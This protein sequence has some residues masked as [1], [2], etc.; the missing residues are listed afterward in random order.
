MPSTLMGLERRL[1]W[2]DFA[3]VTDRPAGVP[4]GALAETKTVRTVTG[5]SV[6]NLAKAGQPDA[7]AISDSFVMHLSLGPNSW[8]LG[9]NSQRSTS[10]EAWLLA[11]EQGHYDI[12][13]L[14]S[15]DY[16]EGLRAM[17]GKTF[18]SQS[19]L[20]G[21]MASLKV[22]ILDRIEEVQHAYDGDTKNSQNGE[23]QWNWLGLIRRARELHR[24]PLQLGPDGRYLKL[25]LLSVLKGRSL[26]P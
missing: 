23:E 1:K 8:R 9:S 19:A 6:A 4:D 2:S 18:P 21:D 10:E 12:F 5:F 22:E 20:V 24:S 26:V 15:R 17:V 16:F 11:H 7:Y 3:S 25:E 13:A 14:M